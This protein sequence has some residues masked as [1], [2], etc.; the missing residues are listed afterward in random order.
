MYWFIILTKLSG[1]YY[2]QVL[3]KFYAYNLLLFVKIQ[4]VFDSYVHL[5]MI[6][7]LMHTKHKCIMYH[8]SFKEK[9]LQ[10]V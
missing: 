5:F 10:K 8:L 9:N 4:I 6:T 2:H 7:T 3:I 1:I